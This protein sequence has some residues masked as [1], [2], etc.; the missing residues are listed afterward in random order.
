MEG[1]G[2]RSGESTIR[3][4]E[5]AAQAPVTARVI[6]CVCAVCQ[7]QMTQLKLLTDKHPKNIFKYRVI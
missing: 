1:G 3:N 2:D 7:I 5:K 6:N 4:D